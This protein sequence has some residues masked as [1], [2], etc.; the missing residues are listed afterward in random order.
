[1]CIRDRG[2]FASARVCGKLTATA[3]SALDAAVAREAPRM[4]ARDVAS[5][6]RA[7]AD[8]GEGAPGHGSVGPLLKAALETAASMHP[9]DARSTLAAIKRMGL[10][11][12]MDAKT[13]RA[14]EAAAAA[15][16]EEANALRRSPTA[17]ERR[18]ARRGGGRPGEMR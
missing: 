2:A 1:M 8:C 4:Y 10:G 14:L 18:E 7:Y 17:K 16:G 5:V 15:T 9:T 12:A 6:A 11:G 13:R 3:R